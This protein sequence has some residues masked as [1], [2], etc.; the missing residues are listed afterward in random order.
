MAKENK[1]LMLRGLP[2]SGKST[3]AKELTTQGWKRV[4]KDELRLMVDN[5]KWSRENEKTILNIEKEIVS[6]LLVN[7][8]NVVVDD[9]NFAHEDTW[10][11]VAEEHF[12]NFEIKEFRVPLMECIARDSGRPNPVGA[13]VIYKMYARYQNAGIFSKNPNLIDTYL[14][15]IDGTLAHMN[16]RSPYDASKALDDTL[17]NSVFDVLNR[18]KDSGCNVI[19]MSGRS[20]SYF[21][22]TV[23]WLEKHHIRYDDIFMRAE[24]DNRKDSVIKRELYDKNI[25]DK[26]NVLGVFDDRNQVVDMWR[27]LGIKCYQVAYGFF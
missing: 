4:N 9:T 11:T 14:F 13:E 16:N 5:G 25:K 10:K 7:G 22:V 18:I 6:A 15:D 27:D 21:D 3:Y 8:F 26:Y 23:K 1:L 19:I 2:A 20:I 12:V 24:G 17:D